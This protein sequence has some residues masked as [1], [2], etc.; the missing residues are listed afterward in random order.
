MTNTGISRHEVLR[1]GGGT[2]IGQGRKTGSSE[3]MFTRVELAEGA[4]AGGAGMEISSSTHSEP[5]TQEGTQ[6]GCGEHACVPSIW[7]VQVGRLPVQG[8]PELHREFLL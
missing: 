3:D 7:E 6:T 8:Q 5:Q 2:E 1:G 4:F